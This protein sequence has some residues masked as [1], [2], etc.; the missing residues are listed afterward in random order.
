MKICGEMMMMM[1][2]ML[3][4]L[5]LMMLMMMKK[6]QVPIFLVRHSDGHAHCELAELILSWSKLSASNW[7]GALPHLPVPRL[8][9]GRGAL[10]GLFLVLDWSLVAS[11]EPGLQAVHRQLGARLLSLYPRPLSCGTHCKIP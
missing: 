6:K 10:S 4:L 8:S 3:M 1:M 2:M 5:M 11:W 7:S 9:L